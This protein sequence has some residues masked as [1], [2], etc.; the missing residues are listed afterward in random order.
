MLQTTQMD[1]K[2]FNEVTKEVIKAAVNLLT[3]QKLI[4]I[5]A[6]RAGGHIVGKNVKIGLER[7]VRD[8]R[9]WVMKNSKPG[10]LLNKCNVEFLLQTAQSPT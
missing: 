6:D 3:T 10:M 8:V 4:R 1:R 9:H 2:K 7:S 5:I